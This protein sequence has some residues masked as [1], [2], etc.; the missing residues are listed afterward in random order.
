MTPLGGLSL[1]RDL[2]HLSRAIETVLMNPMLTSSINTTPSLGQQH[3]PS[4]VQS[5]L[6]RN[7]NGSIPTSPSSSSSHIPPPP[8]SPLSSPSLLRRQSSQLV[9][10]ASEATVSMN[11]RCAILDA[12]LCL[13]DSTGLLISNTTDLPQALENIINKSMKQSSNNNMLGVTSNQTVQSLVNSSSS[14]LH[15]LDNNFDNSSVLLNNP[16]N[17]STNNNFDVTIGSS[18]QAIALY[19]HRESNIRRFLLDLLKCRSDFRDNYGRRAPWVKE[20]FPDFTSAG[21]GVED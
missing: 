18:P 2:D 4:H 7:T 8:L 14:S 13:K 17:S 10:V 15:S 19:H 21:I 1:F 20:L 3:Q 6:I 9:K 11:A 5:K 16:H 12:Y